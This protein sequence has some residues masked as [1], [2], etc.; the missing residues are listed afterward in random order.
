MTPR[1]RIGHPA[2]DHAPRRTE[3]WVDERVATHQ[4]WWVTG[5]PRAL[6]RVARRLT[7]S[8]LGHVEYRGRHLV[9]IPPWGAYTETYRTALRGSA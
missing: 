6:A 8:A 2:E 7:R 3:V 5:S 4:L 1:A 9:V